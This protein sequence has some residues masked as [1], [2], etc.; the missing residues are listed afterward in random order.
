[1]IGNTTSILKSNK[2]RFLRVQRNMTQ[3]DLGTIIGLGPGAIGNYERGEADPSIE[4]LTKLADFFEVSIDF[5]IGRTDIKDRPETI[6]RGTSRGITLMDGFNSLP[7]EA[8]KKVEE[9]FEMVKAFY[10]EEIPGDK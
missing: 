7:E 1:M 3:A 5:L 10:K 9:I 2:I 8:Q 4:H 6:V